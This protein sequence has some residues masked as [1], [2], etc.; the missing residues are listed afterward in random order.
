M[1]TVFDRLSF[2]RTNYSP[3]IVIMPVAA[4]AAEAVPLAAARPG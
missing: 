2:V 3:P 4:F 1:C